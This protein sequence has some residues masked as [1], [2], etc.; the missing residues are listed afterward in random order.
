MNFCMDIPTF[1]N[2]RLVMKV[3]L[4]Y[5]GLFNKSEQTDDNHVSYPNAVMNGDENFLELVLCAVEDEKFKY[6]MDF[7]FDL[8]ANAYHY[9]SNQSYTRMTF[10]E[11]CAFWKALGTWSK[12]LRK[13]REELCDDMLENVGEDHVSSQHKAAYGEY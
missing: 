13:E 4:A 5:R 3:F 7:A 2:A 1:P 10:K 6:M 12:E 8:L 11:F 9:D